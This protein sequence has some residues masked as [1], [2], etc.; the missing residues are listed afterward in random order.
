MWEQLKPRNQ[1]MIINASYEDFA[2]IQVERRKNKNSEDIV[3]Y[4]VTVR[5]ND[6]TEQCLDLYKFDEVEKA[7]AFIRREIEELY[8]NI[9]LYTDEEIEDW[10]EN[11]I[12][13]ISEY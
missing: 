2:S 3:H 4:L 12:D 7:L 5:I 8:D 10:V 13:L 6:I 9:P 1:D 11:F